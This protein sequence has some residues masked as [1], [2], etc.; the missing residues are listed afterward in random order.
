MLPSQIQAQSFDPRPPYSLLPPGDVLERSNKGLPAA[1]RY[2][3]GKNRSSKN[4]T[5]IRGAGPVSVDL[6][7]RLP[8]P[9]DSLPEHLLRQLRMESRDPWML[10]L[11]EWI[12]WNL[13]PDGYLR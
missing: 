2:H 9:G 11:A 3:R 7:D 5:R 12:V 13:S 1:T 10:A 6:V 4:V 8:A